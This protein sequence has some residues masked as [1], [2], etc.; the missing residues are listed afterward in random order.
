MQAQ[1]QLRLEAI[2]FQFLSFYLL[3]IASYLLSISFHL[4][5][6]FFSFFG[7]LVHIPNLLYI[8]LFFGTIFLSFCF[9]LFYRRRG[10]RLV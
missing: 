6:L 2:H 10:R 4:F 8:L 3:V 9:V 1:A 5:Q 7:H